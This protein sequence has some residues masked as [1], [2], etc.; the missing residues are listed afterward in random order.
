MKQGK[1]TK[2]EEKIMARTGMRPLACLR[3]D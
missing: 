2:K 3:F 1:K